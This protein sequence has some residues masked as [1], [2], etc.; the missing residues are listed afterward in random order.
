MAEIERVIRDVPQEEVALN[1]SLLEADGFV[2]KVD[3]QDDGLFTLTG[4]KDDGNS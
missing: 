4:T 2:V 1:K 3:K